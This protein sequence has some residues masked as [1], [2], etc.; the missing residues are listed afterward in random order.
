[1]VTHWRSLT[2]V[3]SVFGLP[4]IGLTLVLPESPRWLQSKNKMREAI[5]VLK[6]IAKKNGK[7]LNERLISDDKGNADSPRKEG[8]RDNLCQLCQRFVLLQLTL[9]QVYSWFVN[10]ATYYGLTLAASKSSTEPGGNRYVETALSGAVELPAY[11]ITTFLL[12]VRGR[13]FT[14][15]AFMITGGSALIAVY[16]IAALHPLIKVVAL[17]AKLCISAS[18]AVIYIH[19]SEIFPTTIRNSAMGEFHNRGLRKSTPDL[20][21]FVG[22]VSVAARA[23]GILAPFLA[24]LSDYAD[25]FDLIVFGLLTLSAGLLNLNLPETKG[26]PLPDTIPD[27]LESLSSKTKSAVTPSTKGYKKLATKEDV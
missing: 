20:F 5:L 14:L 7:T 17:V 15:C 18:F 8:Q 1:M 12:T 6:D 9:I 4:I 26:C 21:Y 11:V 25:N 13:R 16:L 24:Q 10:S 22:I 19:S 3:T 27:L 23:G 2:L